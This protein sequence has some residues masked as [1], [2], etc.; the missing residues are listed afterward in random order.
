M[1]N[2]K[3]LQQTNLFSLILIILISAIQTSLI[4]QDNSNQS[5]SKNI[6]AKDGLGNSY[7][8][9]NFNNESLSFGN[10]TLINNG[11]SDIFLAKYDSH[12]KIVW[13]KNIGGNNNEKLESLIIEPSGNCKV[14]A[15]SFSKEINIADK[16]FSPEKSGV[17]FNAEIT[18]DGRTVSSKVERFLNNNSNSILKL[19]K[20]VSDTLISIIAPS[21]GDNLK[22]GTR[23]VIQWNAQNIDYVLIELSLDNG[24]T[25]QTISINEND[26]E[27]N[28]VVPDTVSSSCLLRISDYDNREIAETSGTFTIYGKMKWK[29]QSANYNSV[30]QDICIS[31]P[32]IT[33]AVGY[34]GLI[35]TTN[36][37]ATWRSRLSGYCLFDVFFFNNRGWAVGLNGIIFYTLDYGETWFEISCGYNFRL[38][39]IYFTDDLVGYMLGSGYLLKTFDGGE[40]WRILNPTDHV[41]QNMYFLNRDTGWVAGG[42]G[43]ILKTIDGGKSWTYQQFNGAQY[44]TLSSI[45]FVD[46]QNGWACGSGLDIYGGVILKT[47]DGGES[48]KLQHSGDNLFIY[49]VCF[50]DVNTGWAVGDMGIMFSTIDGGL[51]WIEEGSGTLSDLNAVSLLGNNEGW[52]IGNDGV[53]LKYEPDSAVPVELTNFTSEINNNGVE[54]KW[55]TTTEINNKGFEVERK[56]LNTWIAIGFIGGKGTTTNFTEYNFVDELRNIEVG[57]KIYYRL[58]QIDFDGAYTYSKELVANYN[59]SV[60]EYSLNQNYPNPFNPST[61][62]NYSLLENQQVTLKVYDILGNEVATLVNEAKQPG[63]YSVNFNASNLASGTYIYCLTAGSFSQVKKM[64]LI[65]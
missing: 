27:Y 12:S 5:S 32:N 15:T 43:T 58:K 59:S 24:T 42:E 18:S 53:V 51:S 57:S 63:K 40:T 25:W 45:F 37:G 3:P 9:G 6:I 52:V 54:L 47:S 1:Y 62:I 46:N 17:V 8:A 16:M 49:S 30:L 26:L 65:K 34:N 35:E 33:W 23:E 14:T 56:I 38:E 7:I 20:A 2:L 44:G 4:A 13:A 29:I 10:T 41:I 55:S 48:W 11:Q 61:N 28:W 39:K 19:S 64:I 22:V 50:T 60:S 36:K 31:D 21:T